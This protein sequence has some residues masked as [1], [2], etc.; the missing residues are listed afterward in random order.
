MPIFQDISFAARRFICGFLE[1]SGTNSRVGRL[2]GQLRNGE[3]PHLL[4][5]KS[6][7]RI[8]VVEDEAIVGMLIEDILSEY[9]CEHVD[10]APSVDSALDTLSGDWPDFAI[11]DVNLNGSRSYPVADF[12]KSRAIPF[13]FMSGY[14]SNALDNAYSDVKVLQKPF[15][16]G[17]LESALEEVLSG[18]HLAFGSC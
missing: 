6:N 1:P 12:L 2:L 16:A 8:L 17:D 4:K 3:W 5:R 10:V 14:G 9:G 13:I 18:S 15:R 7:L 11:L